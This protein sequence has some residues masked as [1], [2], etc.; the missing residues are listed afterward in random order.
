MFEESLV[1]S[2]PLLRTGNRWPALI[3]FFIQ[4]AFLLAL[5]SIPIFHPEIVHLRTPSLAFIAPPP[6]PV[7]PPPQPE[8]IHVTTSSNTS[9]TAATA[10]APVSTTRRTPSAA[11]PTGDAPDFNPTSIMTVESPN[12]FGSSVP[13]PP[14]PHVV[15]ASAP[16]NAT[17]GKP[18]NI[19]TGVLTGMLL[20]PI[21]PIYPPIARAAGIGGT[22]IIQA[23]ISKTGRIESAHAVSGPAMLQGAAIE[24]VRNARYRPFLLN[25]QPTEVETTININFHLGS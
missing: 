25:G 13:G 8:R 3:S 15:S 21:Q 23:T 5:I 9:T 18:L 11:A 14:S 20:A 4:A 16:G 10:A 1:E 12:P 22:V 2:T 6:R 7:Q 19:S 17:S 24:A